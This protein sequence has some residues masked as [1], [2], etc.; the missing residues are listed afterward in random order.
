MTHAVLEHPGV[1]RRV[2]HHV[3]HGFERNAGAR[4]QRHRFR[5]DGD[6]HACQQ[7]VNNFNR[8]AEADFAADAVDLSRH[9][10]QHRLQALE[11]R[12]AAGRHHRHFARCRFRRAAGD[13]RVEHQQLMLRQLLFNL[14]RVLR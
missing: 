7:L 4:R 13:R 10:I 12:V 2:G 3:I 1:A 9:R 11:R 5:A 6:M 14:L 8:R